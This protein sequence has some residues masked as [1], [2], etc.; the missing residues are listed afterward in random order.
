MYYFDKDL[1]SCK[2]SQSIIT[3]KG[4]KENGLFRLDYFSNETGKILLSAHFTDS[5]LSV[6]QGPFTSFYPN[7]SV[8]KAGDYLQDYKEGLWQQWNEEGVKTD[9]IIY[10]HDNRIRFAKFEFYKKEKLRSGYSYTDSLANTFTQNH[11]YLN[12]TVSSEVVFTG[13]KGLWKRY[14]STGI[15]TKTDSVFSRAEE[16]AK[17]PGGDAAWRAFLVKNLNVEVPSNNRAPGGMYTVIVKFVVT[18]D[19]TLTDVFAET[20][21]GYGAEVEAIRVIK[22]SPKWLPAKQYGMPVNAYRRQPISFS[23]SN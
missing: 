17:F 15:L 5:T 9:S 21:V 6:L 11:Y 14:D 3:G 2:K 18:K 1:L 12:G 13:Q 19:G 10:E 8:E 7:T 16:E 20:F 22:K 23:V 4:L